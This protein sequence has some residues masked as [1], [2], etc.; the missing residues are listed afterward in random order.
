M[1]NATVGLMTVYRLHNPNTATVAATVEMR[2]LSLYRTM[3][4]RLFSVLL[5]S[6]LLRMLCHLWRDSCLQDTKNGSMEFFV[7]L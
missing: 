2:R 5:F 1:T 4:C 7:K 6:P 3:I